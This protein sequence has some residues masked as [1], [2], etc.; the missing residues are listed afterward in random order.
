MYKSKTVLELSMK[1]A[2][3]GHCSGLGKEL[4]GRF[5]SIGFDL[6]NGYNIANPG[7]IIAAAKNCDVFI[8]NAY[9]MEHQIEMFKVFEAEWINTNKLIVNISSMATVLGNKT[10]YALN[11]TIL[12]KHSMFSPCKVSVI[13]PGLMDTPMVNNI[14]DRQ[15]MDVQDVA[16]VIEFVIKSPVHIPLMEITNG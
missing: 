1:V 16:D 13:R 4:Y 2:I 3:T 11:K 15:K 10:P 5:N 7:P 9:Y 8:N 14:T 12:E 6:K